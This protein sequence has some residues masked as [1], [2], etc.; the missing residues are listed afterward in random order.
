M[1]QALTTVTFPDE[2]IAYRGQWSF[3]SQLL[4]GEDLSFHTSSNVGDCASVRFNGER[5]YLTPSRRHAT[6]TAAFK[7]P[8]NEPRRLLTL[9]IGSWSQVPP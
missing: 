4:P 9:L 1:S 2:L 7:T 6:V 8:T 3:N 5:S